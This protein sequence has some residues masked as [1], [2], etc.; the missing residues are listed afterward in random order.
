MLSIELFESILLKKMDSN[1]NSFN[2]QNED[3]SGVSVV[4]GGRVRE[5]RHTYIHVHTYIHLLYTSTV[6]ILPVTWTVGGV[7]PSL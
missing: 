4:V 1:N 3:M 7:W 5:G 2:P 6:Y